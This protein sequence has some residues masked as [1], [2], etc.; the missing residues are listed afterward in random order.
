MTKARNNCPNQALN[1][2]ECPC[3]VGD[4]PRRGICCECIEFHRKIDESP[5][6]IARLGDRLRLEADAETDA[7]MGEVEA[8]EPRADDI[9]IIDYASCAG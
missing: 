2:E 6:C 5:A 7:Q 8:V 3:D 4:C 9:R 1:A